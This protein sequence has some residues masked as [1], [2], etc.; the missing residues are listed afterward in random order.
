[1]K[2]TVE[3]GGYREPEKNRPCE[4]E[5]YLDKKG[6]EYLAKHLSTLNEPGDHVH[7]MTSSWGEGDLSE[8]KMVKENDLAHH[9]RLTLI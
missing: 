6:I 5:V 2:I 4:V 7:F 9:L 1:M 8:D 3:I